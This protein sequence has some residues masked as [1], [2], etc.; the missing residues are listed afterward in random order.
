M[1]KNVV[2]GIMDF[3]DETNNEVG[4]IPSRRQVEF[5]GGYVNN[6]T[7][8]EFK[9]Y[10]H[11]TYIMR[12]HSGPNQGNAVDDGYESL[13]IDCELFD[14]IHIDPWKKYSE[15]NQGLEETIKMIKFCYSINPNLEFEVA[16]EQ[17]I[18]HFESYEL[19]K[20]ISDLKKGLSSDE[21]KQIKYL[22]I[23]SGTSLKENENTGK[24]D[25]S[26]LLDMISIC[27]K[28]NLLSKEHNGDYQSYELINEK[29]EMGLNSMNIAPE[30]GLIETEVYL[31]KINQSNRD[32]LF[33]TFYEICYLSK[34]WCKWVGADFVPE[35]NKE[36]LIR[37]CGHY[38]ISNEDFINKIKS[39][40]IGIDEVIKQ[41]VKT[42]LYKLYGQKS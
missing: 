38:V 7:T 9:E 17:S 41:Q 25:K 20:L 1:T 19:D 35:N 39:E 40:F 2:D 5:D 12:D 8:K 29:F 31:D 42:K 30:F 4:L 32:D 6:W 22:V 24:Y 28:Y 13:S 18:R 37:I 3:C 33:E 14:G 27:Q 21:F 11:T 10:I 36:E 34:R 23:Q 26:R 16:T 15:Y